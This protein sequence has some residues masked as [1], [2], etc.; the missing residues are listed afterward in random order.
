MNHVG[1][2][3][4]QLIFVCVMTLFVAACGETNDT[5]KKPVEFP[6]QL[7]VDGKADWRTAFY[8]D[9]RGS[10]GVNDVTHDTYAPQG[11]NWYQGYEIELEAGDVVDLRVGSTSSGF[12]PVMGLYGPQRPSG[13]WGNLVAA[14]DDS[15]EG[16]TYDSYIGWEADRAG[17]YLIIVQEYSWRSG[18]F[19][20][21][22]ECAGGTCESSACSE[23]L[24]ALYCP[25]GNQI[26]SNGCEICACNEAP[27]CQWVAPPANVRCI[28]Q[29]T[30]AK[31]PND[32]T[33]CEYDSPCNVPESWETFGSQ[34]ECQGRAGLGEACSMYVT[35]CED[36]LECAY[37]CVDGGTPPNCNMGFNPHGTCQQ[38]A[39]CQDGDS[40]LADDGCNTC[41][42]TGG[43]WACTKRACVSEC[44][45][46]ADCV[47]SGCSGQICAAEPMI[48]TCEWRPEYACYGEP[49]TSCGCN[50]GTCG[51]AQTRELSSCLA[52]N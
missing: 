13:A 27:S 32:D 45:T 50:N 48:S 1:E 6:A 33:C 49:T 21:S 36:G 52:G 20:V 3:M 14:N 24:C 19:Y 44:T 17:T 26:D 7:G 8:T 22:A 38:P 25:Y 37:E 42:C 23:V 15:P 2:T 16:G 39:V 35:E 12:D 10:V 4:K 18:D 41:H 46:D 11:G 29:I 47:V 28:Q 9:F 51:W 31:N 34:S 30:W 43:Q 40:R 5:S